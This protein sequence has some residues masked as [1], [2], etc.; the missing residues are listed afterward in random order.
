MEHVSE[1]TALN[2]VLTKLFSLELPLLRRKGGMPLGTSTYCVARKTS[3]SAKRERS[4]VVLS[5]RPVGPHTSWQ[6]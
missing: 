4:T 6:P 3:A 1:P 2:E 5:A